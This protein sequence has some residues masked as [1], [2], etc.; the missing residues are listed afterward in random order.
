[1]DRI[2]K[3]NDIFQKKYPEEWNKGTRVVTARPEIRTNSKR[4]KK[5]WFVTLQKIC[6]SL[7]KLGEDTFRN[8]K[9]DINNFELCTGQLCEECKPFRFDFKEYASRERGGILETQ[10]LGGINPL[11]IRTVSITLLPF[12]CNNQLCTHFFIQSPSK[13]K[14]GRACPF[15]VKSAKRLCGDPNCASICPSRSMINHDNP[16]VME[17][18]SPNN[19]ID[20]R[21]TLKGSGIELIL[22]CPGCSIEY[23]RNNR[24]INKTTQLFCENCVSCKTIRKCRTCENIFIPGKDRCNC[25]RGTEIPSIPL[26]GKEECLKC[27]DRSF[28]KRYEE[29]KIKHEWN[30]KNGSMLSASRKSG[31]QYSFFCAISGKEFTTNLHRDFISC[32]NKYC[33]GKYTT[34][35]YIRQLVFE[36]TNHNFYKTRSLP[37]LIDDITGNNLELDLYSE[38]L[39]IAF[40]Y[41][42]EQH[43]K[44]S[45]HNDLDLFKLENIKRKD[46]LKIKL[47]KENNIKLVV[48]PYTITHTEMYEYIKENIKT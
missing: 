7:K 48:I 44:L 21:T 1:M 18:F 29:E 14:E 17:C 15:C 22:I 28:K 2:Q 38:E 19:T 20:P 25:C 32:T 40:E 5:R 43:Y 24:T 10:L 27:Y 9:F 4:I 13:I 30:I 42:G 23:K 16:H 8:D 47:C 41:Q 37:W 36:I 3:Y 35:D 46:G 34:E 6:G 31:K 12:I 39:K 11:T 33:C 26:C 45:F